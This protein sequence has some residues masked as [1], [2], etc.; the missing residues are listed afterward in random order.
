MTMTSERQLFCLNCGTALHADSHFCGQCAV[1]GADLAVI[2]ERATLRWQAKLDLRRNEVVL[3]QLALA[4]SLPVILT[5]LFI[6]FLEWPLDRQVLQQVILIA[7]TV[8]G[9]LIVL[10][11][12][13]VELFYRGEYEYQYRLDRKGI[14]AKTTGRTAKTNAIVNTLLILSGRP[15]QAGAGILAQSRQVEYV[16]WKKV[17][18]FRAHPEQKTI[19]LY[20]G[21]H[22]L[23]VVACADQ[24]YETVLQ[25]AQAACADAQAAKRAWNGARRVNDRQMTANVS[26]GGPASAKN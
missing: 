14:R 2:K 11:L 5:F 12:I 3:K 1:D 22:P 25:L 15:G 20:R 19:T 4:L 6:L 13:V 16:A 17:D 9:L 24:L 8:T 7:L 18:G 10:L 23:M 26:G 21:K